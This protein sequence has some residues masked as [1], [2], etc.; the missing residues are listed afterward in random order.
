MNSYEEKKQARVD[1][2]KEKAIKTTE[3]SN[4][5]IGQADKMISVIPLGQPILVGHH[6]E[7][8]DR[9]YRNRANA[10]F[11]K[12]MKEAEKAEYYAQK[13]EAA[14]NNKAISSDDPDAIEKLKAKAIA[15]GKRQAEMKQANAYY[16]KHKTMKG[17]P[18]ITDDRADEIDREIKDGYSFHQQPYPAY[19]LQNNKA[20]ISRTLDRIKALSK[21]SASVPDG[22]EFNGGR[23]VM[24]AGDNRIQIFFDGIPKEDVRS[25]LK[26]RGFRW[27][28]SVKAWQRQL[29]D[30][31]LFAVKR[32][33]SIQR[34]NE[35]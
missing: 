33:K 14:E 21:R 8:R 25:E 26:S 20:N 15:L 9:N 27:A 10:K 5:L 28:P 13:A 22:W 12:G 2:Y 32:I 35:S 1:Y 11:A 7:K 30:N 3:R 16:K 34:G 6:S 31:G 29:T 24:N 17:Y 19:M 23:V 18:G 4:Q